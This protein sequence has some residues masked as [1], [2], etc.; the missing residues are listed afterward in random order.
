MYVVGWAHMQLPCG[1]PVMQDARYAGMLL[2]WCCL[3]GDG[4]HIGIAACRV[5]DIE[6]CW[7]YWWHCL[8][9]QSCMCLWGDIV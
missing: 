9:F 7:G 1:Y 2:V 4:L 3:K 6:G 8:C 5:A